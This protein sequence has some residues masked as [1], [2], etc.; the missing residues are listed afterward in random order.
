MK[1]KKRLGRMMAGIVSA[2]SAVSL[3]SMMLPTALARAEEAVFSLVTDY[4]YM[5][6]IAGGVDDTVVF[7]A[8]EGDSLVMG[9]LTADGEQS[10]TA[11]DADGWDALRVPSVWEVTVHGDAGSLC[12]YADKH[13]E[14]TV[15][16]YLDVDLVTVTYRP[17]GS[18]LQNVYV[19]SSAQRLLPDGSLHICWGRYDFVSPVTLIRNKEI[20]RVALKGE[21]GLWGV[22]DAASDTML[23][24]FSYHDMRA[25][26][27]DRVKVGDGTKWG[28]LDLTS[29]SNDI[30]YCYDSADAFSVT[31]EIRQ[32]DDGRWQVFNKD[33]EAVSAVFSG[34]WTTASYEPQTHLVLMT[35]QDGTQTVYD[36]LGR[37]AA[38]FS[39]LQTVRYLQ[40]NCYAVESR[41]QAG[42]LL[43][44]ALAVAK[45]APTPD[46][47]LLL[48]D[49][50]LDCT[51]DSADVRLLL[52]LI[53]DG[54]ELAGR[55]LCA[56]DVNGDGSTDTKDARRILYRLTAQP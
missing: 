30:L 55:R 8:Y 42:A 52:C 51:V 49:V 13:K 17:T 2:V 11:Y 3:L 10:R 24:D 56:A 20:S 19:A 37:E 50:N 54:T 26:Y 5:Q 6:V 38:S 23:T 40:D 48:G 31:E 34:E 46:D 28:C 4:E 27:G 53:T 41:T 21:N 16:P 43:G 35:A 9:T 32:I 12:P 18:V 29:D 15:C 7:T 14:N 39:S 47:T 22:Y 36:L 25:V 44:I 1:K 33:N 45:G